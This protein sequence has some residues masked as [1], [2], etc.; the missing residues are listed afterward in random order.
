MLDKCIRDDVNECLVPD[1]SINRLARDAPS[2]V[3]S[4]S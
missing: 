1:T 3:W 4:G 2:A